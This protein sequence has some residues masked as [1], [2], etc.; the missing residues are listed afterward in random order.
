MESRKYSELIA[1]QRRVKS[2]RQVY[3]NIITY[4]RLKKEFRLTVDS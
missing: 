2:K 4:M 3:I 1:C